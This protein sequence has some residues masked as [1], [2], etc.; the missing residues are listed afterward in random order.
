MR[1]FACAVACAGTGALTGA[2]NILEVATERATEDR[3]E[4]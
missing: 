3:G 4:C 1:R 2:R